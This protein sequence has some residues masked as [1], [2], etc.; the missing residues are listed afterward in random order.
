MPEATNTTPEMT[1]KTMV[2]NL[3]DAV[4][5][6]ATEISEALGRRVSRRTIYRWAKGESEPQQSSDLDELRKVYQ[7]RADNEKAAASA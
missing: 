6:S 3:M 1:A 5:M 4:G 2:V 7:E